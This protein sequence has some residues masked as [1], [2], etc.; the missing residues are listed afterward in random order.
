M[1]VTF[2][3]GCTISKT[4][5]NYNFNLYTIYNYT[6]S[7]VTDLVL[8]PDLVVIDVIGICGHEYVK[9]LVSNGCVASLLMDF[10]YR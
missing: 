5:L 9:V 6:S 3:F 4:L 2:Q 10:L 8:P 7:V 1:K